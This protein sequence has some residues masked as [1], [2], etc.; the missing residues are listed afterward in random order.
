MVSVRENHNQSERERHSDK[1]QANYSAFQDI[2][3]SVVITRSDNGVVVSTNSASAKV[4]GPYKVRSEDDGGTVSIRNENR[5]GWYNTAEGIGDAFEEG[6]NGDFT[7]Q[8]NRS[9]DYFWD[10]SLSTN[11]SAFNISNAVNSATF[12][13]LSTPNSNVVSFAEHSVVD[14]TKG[15]VSEVD[16]AAKGVSTKSEYLNP[17]EVLPG[18]WMFTTHRCTLHV[19]SGDEIVV[20]STMGGLQLNQGLSDALFD[21]PTQ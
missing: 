3:Y 11:R 5:H 17:I 10:V 18:K 4:K 9:S 8:N 1:I 15:F 14:H 12:D 20:E 13:L 6:F 21:I 7:A 19:D 2:Q 16:L